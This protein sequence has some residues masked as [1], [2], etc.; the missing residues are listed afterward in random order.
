MR[1]AIGLTLALVLGWSLSAMALVQWWTP[2]EKDC[3]SFTSESA[4]TAFCVQDPTRCG[5]DTTCI[6]HSGPQNPGC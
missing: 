5:G 2:Q 4:C 1:S 3:P 6:L